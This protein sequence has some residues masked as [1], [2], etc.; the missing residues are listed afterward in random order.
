MPKLNETFNE[1]LTCGMVVLRD[2]VGRRECGCVR[3]DH[4]FET[5]ENHGGDLVK[6]ATVILKLGVVRLHL[7]QRTGGEVRMKLQEVQRCVCVCV[8]VCVYG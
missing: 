1:H 7:F 2:G 5:G 6:I 3:E 8:C 4:H